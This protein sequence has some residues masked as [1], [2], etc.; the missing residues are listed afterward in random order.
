MK[1]IILSTIISILFLFE[2][3]AQQNYEVNLDKSSVFWI[4]EKVT[5]SH[6]GTINISNALFLFEDEKLIGGEFEIDMN[7]IR[8]TD[9]ENPKYAKKLED[10]LKDG[11]F[12]SSDKYPSSTFAITKVIFDGTSYMITGDITIK[13]IKQEII[14][15]VQFNSYGNT[16]QAD[17]SIK[18]DRTKHDIKYGSGSFF[19][20]LGDRMIY[21]EFTLKIH[22]EANK[23]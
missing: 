21:D 9:I 17:A 20:D 18:I 19:D 5:G 12:F 22:L 15:P 6:S 8:C 7:S 14:F 3:Q 2:I 13:D 23:K 16:F 10:H 11:D 1:N 4:G